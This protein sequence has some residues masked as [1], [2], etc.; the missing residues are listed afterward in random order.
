MLI[1]GTFSYVNFTKRDSLKEQTKIEEVK[2]QEEKKTELED[3]ILKTEEES[4]ENETNLEEQ[5]KSDETN[6]IADNSSSEKKE[7][8]KKET[9]SQNNNAAISTS[10]N[11][12]IV[13]AKK[14]EIW[15]V[16]G[17]TKDQY[18]N[19]PMYSWERVDF[20]SYEECTEHGDSYPPAVNGEV[21]YICRDVKSPSGKYLGTMFDT[22]KLN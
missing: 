16:L 9:T 3:S 8:V 20:D 12:P 21:S 6:K 18:Y 7:Q 14:Q 10:K 22:E 17:M 1:A 5:K 15:E 4:K 19:Q 13:D 2:H 11:D